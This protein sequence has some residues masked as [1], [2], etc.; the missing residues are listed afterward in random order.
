MWTKHLLPPPSKRRQRSVYSRKNHKDTNNS[1]NK[2]RSK[3]TWGPQQHIESRKT[4]APKWKS[5]LV[6]D[7]HSC[8]VKLKDKDCRIDHYNEKIQQLTKVKNI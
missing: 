3:H 2:K 7:L 8:N 1:T 5:E 4:E 6:L